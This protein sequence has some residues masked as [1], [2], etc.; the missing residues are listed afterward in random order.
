MPITFLLD[1]GSNNSFISTKVATHLSGHAILPNPWKVRVADGGILIC[2]QYIPECKWS[3]G[4]VEFCSPFKILPLTGY[5]GIIGMDWLSSHSPQVID[6]QHKWLAFQHK[7][8]WRCL[9]GHIPSDLSYNLI[10]V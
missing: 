5:D 7:G 2:D 10:E 8:A 1:S 3:C 4:S 9:Q 6:W